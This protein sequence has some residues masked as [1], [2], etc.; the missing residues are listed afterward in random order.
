MILCSF[1]M[2][3]M[4]DVVYKS[5]RFFL[6]VPFGVFNNDFKKKISHKTKLFLYLLS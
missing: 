5:L 1:F 2:S 3:C 4:H 6:I